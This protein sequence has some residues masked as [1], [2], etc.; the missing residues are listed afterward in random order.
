MGDPTNENNVQQQP[1]GAVAYEH[2]KKD[3]KMNA[4]KQIQIQWR[5]RCSKLKKLKND[6]IFTSV[7]DQ[8]EKS[9]I[10]GEKC[11]NMGS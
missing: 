2:L 7:Q 4:S 8:A 3:I 6:F 9:H 10:C 11:E 1:S 5:Q